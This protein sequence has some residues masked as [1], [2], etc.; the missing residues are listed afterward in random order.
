M[1]SDSLFIMVFMLTYLISFAITMLVVVVCMIFM[2]KVHSKMGLPWWS[3]LV[4][5]YNSY[6]LLEKMGFNPL[7][8]LLLLVPFANFVALILLLIAAYRMMECF[9]YGIG[10]YL[11][12]FFLTPVALGILAFGSCQYQPLYENRVA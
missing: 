3:A 5:V 10:L 11:V 7:F 4:P 1:D 12:Y 9:G 8:S 6:V 2:C